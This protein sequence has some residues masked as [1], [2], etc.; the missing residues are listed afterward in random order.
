MNF[1]WGILVPIS[2]ITLS[3]GGII[4]RMLL[5]HQRRMAELMHGAHQQQN[6]ATP[7]SLKMQQEILDLKQLVHQQTIALDNLSGKLNAQSNTESMRE[8]VAN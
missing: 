7:E 1:P 6:A 2:A 8:R 3:M 4:I 5:T